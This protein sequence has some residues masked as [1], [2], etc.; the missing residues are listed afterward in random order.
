MGKTHEWSQTERGKALG[1]RADPNNSLQD[2]INIINIPKS[3]VRAINNRGSGIT[4][5]RSGH[6]KKLSTRDIHQIIRYIRTNKSTRRITLTRLKKIFH[7][8]VHENTIR[9]ALQKA[10]YY[11]RVARCHPYLNKHDRKR[12]LKFAKEYKNWTAED[13]VRML[14]SNEMVIKLFM[15]R[16]IRDYI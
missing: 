1:L 5:P 14:F 3:T 7:F 15:K 13:W 11:H 4:K 6:P 16:H 9:N 10:G 2:I 12:R 8:Y